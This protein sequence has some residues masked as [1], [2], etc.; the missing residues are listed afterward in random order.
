MVI[1]SIVNTK[2]GEVT[3]SVII[4]EITCIVYLVMTILNVLG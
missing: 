3:K 1:V 2:L 4:S